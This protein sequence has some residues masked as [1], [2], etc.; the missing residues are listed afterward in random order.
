MFT[1]NKSDSRG[2]TNID[3]LNSYHSFSFG[4]Y[5][6]NKK[7]SFGPIRVLNEDFIAPGGGFP[8]HPHANMEIITYVI[9]GELAHSDSTGNNETI[10]AG[11]FQK[12]T[13][14][15][16]VYHSEFNPSSTDE[17]HLLQIWILPDTKGL[18]P[19]YGTLNLQGNYL[20]NNL[21]KVAAKEESDNL[22]YV[23]QNIEVFVSK[24]DADF[25]HNLVG[26]E[27][28]GIYL[29]L[30]DGELSIND[31]LIATGDSIEIAGET[32]IEIEANKKSHFILFEFPL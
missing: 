20:N 14:G 9:S 26:K 1:V 16:G 24:F 3:W 32:N 7:M 30:I 25:S 12:M 22:I 28:K 17:V 15:S 29:F 31:N 19:S 10:K 6:N 13:A 5:F 8:L 23:S 21:L 2:R 4:D 18:T 27:K 11:E